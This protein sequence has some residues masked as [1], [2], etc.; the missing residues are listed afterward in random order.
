[1]SRKHIIIIIN[2]SHH[3]L[4]SV[5]LFEG[6]SPVSKNLTKT[7]KLTRSML[8]SRLQRASSLSRKSTDG[9]RMAAQMLVRVKYFS[10]VLGSSRATEVNCSAMVKSPGFA[11]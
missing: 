9:S 2:P 3:T 1:M 8:E 6:R 5:D 7:S 11:L 4:R 10:P